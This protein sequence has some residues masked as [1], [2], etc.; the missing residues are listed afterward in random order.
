VIRRARPADR[1][2]LETLQSQLPEPSPSLLAHALSTRGSPVLVSVA[3]ASDAVDAPAL[4][5]GYLLAVDSQATV[6][7]AE[8][9]V[10]SAYRRA[11]RATALLAALF[12]A[13]DAG[14]TVTVAVAPENAAARSLYRSVGF[15]SDGTV[16]DYF[17]DGPALLMRR[18]LGDDVD[19]A[20]RD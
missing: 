10:D 11:G 4:P 2:A 5:V 8:L 3:G 14:T 16:E 7:V 15:R 19:G 20:G 17:D 18:R 13:H 9:V 12:D 6:H 1:A